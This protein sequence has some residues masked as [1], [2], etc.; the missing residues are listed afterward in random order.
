MNEQTNG[1]S[2]YEDV[3]DYRPPYSPPVLPEKVGGVYLEPY[4]TSKPSLVPV[5]KDFLKPRP[6]SIP[7]PVE[8]NHV[9]LELCH[10]S[11]PTS[12]K[13]QTPTETDMYMEMD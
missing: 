6:T 9:Y 4:A 1:N 13:N 3:G 5:E 7:A 10:A 12:D 2:L 8:E 11:K